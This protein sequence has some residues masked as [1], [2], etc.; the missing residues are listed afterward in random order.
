MALYLRK[1]DRNSNHSRSPYP[2]IV[3]GFLRFHSSKAEMA[4]VS[5]KAN[6]VQRDTASR[7][8]AGSPSALLAVLRKSGH[9]YETKV[10]KN[11]VE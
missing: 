5:Y 10:S 11:F 2:H 1:R 3:F 7:K 6:K 4:R 8:R 9:N